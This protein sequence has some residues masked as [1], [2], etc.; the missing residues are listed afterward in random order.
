[1]TNKHRARITWRYPGK[2]GTAGSIIV[3]L[4]DDWTPELASKD[5]RVIGPD[6]PVHP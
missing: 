6:G 1:M 5:V 3:P 2:S 4:T